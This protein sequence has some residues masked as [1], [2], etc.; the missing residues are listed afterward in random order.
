M[1]KDDGSLYMG[2]FFNGKAHG[3]GV[4]IF[5][6]GSYYNG[7]FKDNKADSEQA[8]FKSESVSYAG[9]FK[10]NAYHGLGNEIGNNYEFN[11]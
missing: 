6:N 4:Y 3:S 2:H 7:D 11:G 8:T 9:G 10:N 1:Y 5:S